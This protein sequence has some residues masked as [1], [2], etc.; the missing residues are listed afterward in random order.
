MKFIQKKIN[1]FNLI[2]F[3]STLI[4]FLLILPLSLKINFMQNDDY[5]HYKIMEF[6]VK[7]DLFLVT[8]LGATFISQGL[9]SLP[10]ALVFGIERLPIFTLIIS[11]LNFFIFTKIVR[12]FYLKKDLDALM[13]GLIFFLNPI[14]IYSIFGFMMENYFLFYMLLAIY[15]YK[16]YE[17][18]EKIKNLIIFNFFVLLSFLVRQFGIL[19]S[20]ALALYFLYQKKYKLFIFQTIYTSLIYLFYVLIFPRTPEM[21]REGRVNLE[22]FLDFERVF[23]TSTAYLLYFSAFSLPLILPLF[24]FKKVIKNIYFWITTITAFLL[25]FIL[26]SGGERVSEVLFYLRNTVSRTGFIFTSRLG[27]VPNINFGF[28]LFDIW[29]FFTKISLVLFSGFLLLY[30]KKIISFFSIL[31]VVYLGSQIPLSDV[32]DRYTLFLFPL[33]LLVLLDFYEDQFNRFIYYLS[34]FYL[35]LLIIFNYQASMRFVIA[36]NKMWNQAVEISSSQNISKSKIMPG[37]PWFKLNRVKGDYDYIFSFSKNSSGLGS[38]YQLHSTESIDFNFN[39]YEDS[40]YYIYK[41]VK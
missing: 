3:F 13:I 30:K 37:Y 41:K 18:N 12:N 25:I 8:E 1:K 14:H 38:G 34:A 21:L 29:D 39:L 26:Y 33:G 15:F 28:P 35:V 23:Y 22:V 17:Q 31:Y 40:N 5:V 32:Y 27:E 6:L 36:N 16:K 11:V 19:L 4:L 10:F 20:G 9:L 2:L 7:G 24:N